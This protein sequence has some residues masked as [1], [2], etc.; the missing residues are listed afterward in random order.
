MAG[1]RVGFVLGVEAAGGGPGEKP[2]EVRLDGLGGLA[3]QATGHQVVIESPTVGTAQGVEPGS[4]TDQNDE[5]FA[6]FLQFPV[7][8]FAGR[9]GEVGPLGIEPSG[10]G[11]A[12][13]E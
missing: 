8:L 3:R 10:H 2:L 7:G 13:A 6:G 12:R 1:G 5:G 4:G 9:G 11:R